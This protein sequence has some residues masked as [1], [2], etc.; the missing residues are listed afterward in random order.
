MVI[1]ESGS[2]HALPDLREP[3]TSCRLGIVQVTQKSTHEAP[4]HPS[5]EAIWAVSICPEAWAKSRHALPLL[6]SARTRGRRE[7]RHLV[8]QIND[9]LKGTR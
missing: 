8:I 6:E 5:H 4:I 7:P 2:A 1:H 9:L 3:P